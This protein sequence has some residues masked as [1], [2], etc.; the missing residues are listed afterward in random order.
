MGKVPP[1]KPDEV[2]AVLK[3]LGF[4]EVRQR[5]SHKQFRNST[6]KGTTCVGT[7]RYCMHHESADNHQQFPCSLR[8]AGGYCLTFEIRRIALDE[9]TVETERSEI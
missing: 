7:A 6:G 8:T 2:I 1:L 3:K 4:S 5:G 9:V